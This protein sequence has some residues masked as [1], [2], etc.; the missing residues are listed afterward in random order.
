VPPRR[1]S[2]ATA[3]S[4]ASLPRRPTRGLLNEGIPNDGPYV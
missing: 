4:L 3:S 1:P 2:V